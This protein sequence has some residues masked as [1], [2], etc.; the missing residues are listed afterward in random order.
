MLGCATD[1]PSKNSRKALI[2]ARA[3]GACSMTL[4]ATL[5]PF[6]LPTLGYNCFAFP[7]TMHLILGSEQPVTKTGT[8]QAGNELTLSEQ[9]P[10]IVLYFFG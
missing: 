6:H 5:T 3:S 7:L 9:Q 8:L 4:I 1:D 10:S 2:S